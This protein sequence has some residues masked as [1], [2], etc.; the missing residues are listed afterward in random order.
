MGSWIF[1]TTA[2][3]GEAFVTD[4]VVPVT[5][6]VRRGAFVTD[7]G[8]PVTT[9]VR[10]GALRCAEVCWDAQRC[11]E[12]CQERNIPARGD[13]AGILCYLPA[14]C[15]GGGVLFVPVFK[16]FKDFLNRKSLY[17]FTFVAFSGC[18]HEH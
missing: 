2:E 8:V 3:C 4:C 1:V 14:L 5:T 18:S 7:C 11:A 12:G 17:N 6:E 10:W 15:A 16:H 9:G 13:L